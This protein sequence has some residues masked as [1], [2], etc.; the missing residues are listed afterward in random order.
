MQPVR[1]A[2]LAALLSFPAAHAIPFRNGFCTMSVLA[3]ALGMDTLK[4]LQDEQTPI[5]T[6]TFSE[7][8]V[9]EGIEVSRSAG[10]FLCDGSKATVH[11][12][13]KDLQ[14][15]VSDWLGKVGLQRIPLG[16]EKRDK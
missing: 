6:Q 10:Q 3:I 8:F 4:K 9:K 12:M 13:E 15:P 14:W 7:R 2:V 5:T 11:W 1:I 16:Q